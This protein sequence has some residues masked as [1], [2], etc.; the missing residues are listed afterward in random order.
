MI[1]QQLQTLAQYITGEFDNKKQA[2]AEPAW[3]VHLRLWQVVVPF[4]PKIVL[5]YL[6][7]KQILC[8]YI[9]LIAPA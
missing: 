5:R 7:N 2:A 8:L 1:S 9:N 4:L 3:Y 6:P